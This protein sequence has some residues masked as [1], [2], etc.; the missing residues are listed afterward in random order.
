VREIDLGVLERRGRLDP[1]RDAQ[2]RRPGVGRQKSYVAARWNKEI[3]TSQFKLRL[4]VAKTLMS[5]RDWIAVALS[6]S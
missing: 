6:K 5:R 4:V 2:E 1:L 3:P